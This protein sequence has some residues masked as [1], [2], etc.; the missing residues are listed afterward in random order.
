M[1]KIIAICVIVAL[2]TPLLLIVKSEQ[3]TIEV[4]EADQIKAE[5]IANQTGYSVE[6]VLHLRQ[7][8]YT[9]NKVIDKLAVNKQEGGS[10]DELASTEEQD[11]IA[12]LQQEGY[13]DEDIKEA[14][15]LVQWIKYKIDEVKTLLREDNEALNHLAEK[16][17]V[18]Q[19][20]L[21]TVRLKEKKGT[22]SLALEEYLIAAQLELSLENFLEDE[23]AYKRQRSEKEIT[24]TKDLL[25][26][27]KLDEMLMELL[28]GSKDQEEQ[29]KEGESK[30]L[31]PQQPGIDVLDPTKDLE[32]QHPNLKVPEVKPVNPNKEIQEEISNL[33]P[34]DN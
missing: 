8:G 27:Q 6:Q 34:Y 30:V 15:E 33:L 24:Y 16:F 1:K 26:I 21:W 25:T 22:T 20:I 5:Q 23:E 32:Q 14:K 29:E 13:S 31:E 9:W 3:T 17:D 7:L 2:I 12:L 10:V 18:Q 28:S 19:G 4:S 11:I